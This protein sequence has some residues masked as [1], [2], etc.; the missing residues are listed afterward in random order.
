MFGIYPKEFAK[1]GE[2]SSPADSAEQWRVRVAL[3][4][5]GGSGGIAT[6]DH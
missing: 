5:E 4:R 3:L 2:G 1:I 6:S